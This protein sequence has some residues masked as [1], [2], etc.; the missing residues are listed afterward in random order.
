[1]STELEGCRRA[2]AA[3]EAALE[4]VFACARPGMTAE[5]IDA[6]LTRELHARGAALIAQGNTPFVVA[7]GGAPPKLRFN[8]VPLERGKLWAMDN[9]IR[10]DGLCADLGR[11]GYFG[12]V[13]QA[14]RRAHQ[15]VLDRQQLIERAV[16]PDRGMAEVLD[17]CPQDL[18]FEIHRIGPE[19]NMLPMCGNATRGVLEAMAKCQREGV[20]FEP[21]QVV[22]IEI[23]AGLSGGIEDMYAVGDDS[24]AR[25]SRLPRAIREIP[26]GSA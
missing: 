24:V 6:V 21:G 3:L 26:E 22:C 9:S 2:A 15:Q 13:P 18:P 5:E 23:W 11:Y 12:P 4:A 20:V 1:M 16:R 7:E 10:L 14:L 25:I 19:A 17:S 8:R